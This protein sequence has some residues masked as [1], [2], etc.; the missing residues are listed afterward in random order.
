MNTLHT[1]F[2][3]IIAT[4]L[5]IGGL[6]SCDDSNNIDYVNYNNSVAIS[7]D[8][9][10]FNSGT[11][12]ATINGEPLAVGKNGESYLKNSVL[13]MKQGALFMLRKPAEKFLFKLEDSVTNKEIFAA[14]LIKGD[15]GVFRLKF[16]VFEGKVYD[17]YT[18]QDFSI[19]IRNR[20][21]QK[22]QIISDLLKGDYNE[23]QKYT[24]YAFSESFKVYSPPSGGN[25]NLSFLINDESG[26]TIIKKEIFS[27]DVEEGEYGGKS[28]ELIINS[29]GVAATRPA[30]PPANPNANIVAIYMDNDPWM[31]YDVRI[32]SNS[33]MEEIARIESL[34]PGQWEFRTL[35]ETATEDYYVTYYNAG[36]EERY[37][38]SAEYQ[39]IT[40]SHLTPLLPTDGSYGHV[41]AI[42]LYPDFTE[43][44]QGIGGVELK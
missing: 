21:Q 16:G 15:D 3:R 20:S 30:M 32:F 18:F 7:I 14:P 35:D 40:Y 8:G 34:T 10:F 4:L 24:D 1:I 25:I 29:Q 12:L 26:N 27:D 9:T 31:P 5:L 41:K 23:I 38:G 2:Y 6:N 43:W 19:R 42:Y 17:G 11:A 37:A 13:D 36:T 22:F 44:S 28:I 33:T 39:N